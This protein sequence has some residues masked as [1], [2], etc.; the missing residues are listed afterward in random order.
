MFLGAG[1]RVGHVSNKVIGR[2]RR[3]PYG[4]LRSVQGVVCACADNAG[5]LRALQKCRTR[6]RASFCCPGHHGQPE[7]LWPPLREV[8]DRERHALVTLD[9]AEQP[10]L[11]NLQQPTGILRA[12]QE[13][14]AAVFD[15]VHTFFLV[16][17]STSG[18]L[19]AL[20]AVCSQLGQDPS[21]FYALVPRNAHQSVFHALALTG[22]HPVYLT[23]EVV[24]SRY[25]IL[26]PVSESTIEAALVA[27]AP[28]VAV[29]LLTSPTYHG[30]VA[31]VRSIA[32]RCRR[33]GAWL[34]VDEAHG[35]H[36]GFSPELPQS[37][38]QMGADLVVQSTHK[39]LMALTQAAML[40]VPCG[41][42]LA[43][44][45]VAEA[46]RMVSST[47]PNAWLVASLDATVAALADTPWC[48]AW[49][50]RACTL[51]Q[52]IRRRLP[53][54]PNDDATRCCLL[55]PD[56]IDGFLFDA[57]LLDHYGVYMELAGRATSTGI[58]T[59]ANDASHVAILEEA[60]TALTT[61][62]RL[63][64]TRE[65]RVHTLRPMDSLQGVFRAAS[66][67]LRV[68]L[69]QRRRWCPLQHAANQ[70]ASATISVYPPGIPVVLPG[71]RIDPPLVSYL[72][73]A[74]RCGC[75]ISGVHG[76]E[77]HVAVV[78][79]VPPATRCHQA[80]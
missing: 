49:F 62:S 55:L 57:H 33:Y 26:G 63:R 59:G 1:L 15:T 76:P 29:V 61:D 52:A 58:V 80:P 41:S 50:E 68:S 51:G 53:T 11:D 22:L 23:P 60:F 9:L 28:Q 24:D 19:A 78:D 42:R 12:V 6:I 64:G 37:A 20:L 38:R 67:T 27:F 56:D 31:N 7:K 69:H 44:E 65:S 71:E 46:V 77:Q 72:L 4:F 17:G 18:I 36:L 30:F 40:H 39:T 13:R 47:S 34:V 74:S 25:D 8:L 54:L 2:D 70:V 10:E 16:N 14:A 43:V 45:D 79:D 75:A 21:R 5:F 35:A 66:C 3:Q 73:D 32:A 48:Q